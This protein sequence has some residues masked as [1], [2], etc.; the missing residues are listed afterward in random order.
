[1]TD[2]RGRTVGGRRSRRLEVLL[3][4]SAG[5]NAYFEPAPGA[6]GRD[7][8]YFEVYQPDMVT[9]GKL[10]LDQSH[11]GVVQLVARISCSGGRCSVF[12]AAAWLPAAAWQQH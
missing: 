6:E 11:D 5:K 9:I 2:D 4:T 8:K 3:E 10:T 7:R 1:M 12:L